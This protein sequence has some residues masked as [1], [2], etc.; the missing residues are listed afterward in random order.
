[1]AYRQFEPDPALKPYIETYWAFEGHWVNRETIRL[2]PDGC[3]DLMLNL[4]EDIHL[5]ND[6]FIVK[7]ENAYL[8]GLMSSFKEHFLKG[9][10][11]LFGIR[12]KPGA[13]SHFYQHESLHLLSNQ[14]NEYEL[15][16]FPDIQ[17]LIR[18]KLP[19]LNRFLLDRLKV[20]KNCLRSIVADIETTKGLIKVDELTKKHFITARQLERLFQSQIG[21]SPKAFINLTRFNCTMN[22]IRNR[23]DDK[24]SLMD[25]AF[26]CGYY[27]HAHLANDI[28]NYTGLTPSSIILSDFSKTV[29]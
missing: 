14:I 10:T 27:D 15:N 19:Y 1:M 9:A 7:H 3:I 22:K 28:K 2:F 6:D 29:F 25:I 8:I 16:L 18:F 13:Y 11:F 21:I 26:E 12:F 17:Q 5:V 23:T 20:P 4:G 24:Q